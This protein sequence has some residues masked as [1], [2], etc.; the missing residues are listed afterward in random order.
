MLFG[1]MYVEWVLLASS[2]VVLIVSGL[3]SLRIVTDVGMMVSVT[4]WMS[5]GVGALSSRLSPSTW[6]GSPLMY[7]CLGVMVM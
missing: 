6:T 4:V 2:R 3:S 1:R 7:T 5:V